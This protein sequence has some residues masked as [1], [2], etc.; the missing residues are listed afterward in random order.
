[1]SIFFL[2]VL[3]TSFA[4]G[5][6]IHVIVWRMRRP[7]DDA[8]ALFIVV[9]LLPLLGSCA[10]ASLLTSLR[11]LQL[12]DALFLAC[13]FHFGTG[14]MYMSLYTASQAASPTS[15]ILLRMAQAGPDGI[16]ETELCEQFTSQQLSG[17]SVR[18][19]I[20]EGFLLDAGDGKLLVAARGKAL[21]FVCSSLRRFLR[22]GPGRG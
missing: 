2:S 22:L 12:V 18:S 20:D 6:L 9:V 4:A 15:L 10:G 5:L 19:G 11:S 17:G 8:A 13:I 7:K 3:L 16:S 14:F 1:M 21:L